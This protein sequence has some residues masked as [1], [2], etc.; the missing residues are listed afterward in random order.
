MALRKYMSIFKE[1]SVFDDLFTG[2]DVVIPQNV[3]KGYI[4]QAA[5][6][7]IKFQS[8]SMET[9]SSTSKYVYVEDDSIDQLERLSSD[10][11]GKWDLM[12]PKLVL[13]IISSTKHFT[14]WGFH[15]DIDSFQDGLMKA[16]SLAEMMILVDGQNYGITQIIGEAVAKEK[17]RR[18]I[19]A[20]E[21]TLTRFVSSDQLPRITVIGL[22]PQQVL[23]QA[24]SDSVSESITAATLGKTNILISLS[25]ESIDD[26]INNL[27][28]NLTHFIIINKDL[29]PPGQ[30]NFTNRLELRLS[31]PLGWVQNRQ[32]LLLNEDEVGPVPLI[33]LLVQGGPQEIDRVLALVKRNVPVI[34]LWGLGMAGDIIAYAARESQKSYDSYTYEMYVKAELRRLLS[35]MFPEEFVGNNL[36]RNQCRDRVLQC[37]AHANQGETSLLTLVNVKAH[38]QDL[39]TAILMSVL[40]S[41]NFRPTKTDQIQYSLQL[42]LDWMSPEIALT[43][44]FSKYSRNLIMVTDDMF[45][46]AL[47]RPSREEFVD[48]FLDRGFVLHSFL[49]QTRLATLFERC[50]DKDFFAG[51]CLETILGEKVTQAHIIPETF[52]QDKKCDL[53]RLLQSLTSLTYLIDPEELTINA[54]PD[55]A[56][57][58]AVAEKQVRIQLCIL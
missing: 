36:A 14:S 48:L 46:Q 2:D 44:I 8:E 18:K 37:V 28:S 27:N 41:Y 21:Q 1:K 53:N 49:S 23:S 29:G 58:A 42:C 15:E 17:D 6:G 7:K 12:T 32:S 55:R 43:N 38:S 33:G 24:V 25:D 39:S 52:V 40:N 57:N 9:G 19:L 47:L 10:M 11:V 35:D 5:G 13:T 30:V 50:Q 56:V 26:D 54:G 16:A 51:I 34:V 45:Q 20:R 4:P 3:N 31:R 22:V